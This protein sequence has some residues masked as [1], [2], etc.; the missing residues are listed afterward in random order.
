MKAT[1]TPDPRNWVTLYADDLYSFASARISNRELAKDL[2]QDTFLA[3]LKGYEN[4]KEESSLRTWMTSILKN[5]ITDA[6]RKKSSFSSSSVKEQLQEQNT[7]LFFEQNGHWRESHYP[8]PWSVETSNPLEAREFQGILQQCMDKL[9]ALW[10]SV[11][12]MKH[13]EDEESVT[14]CKEL[15]LSPSNFWVIMHRTKLSL[16]AC[17]E[18]RW[19]Q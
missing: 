17:L 7:D 15:S 6:Y 14:I 8:Q 16:R 4:F 5:K 3:A 12:S 11:F 1:Q 19:M 10:R 2:V 13:L 9:P 18:K